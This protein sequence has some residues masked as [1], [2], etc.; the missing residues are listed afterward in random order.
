MKRYMILAAIAAALLF[1]TVLWPRHGSETVAP[2]TS[3]ATPQRLSP[4][5]PSDR[6][7][8]TRSPGPERSTDPESAARIE[9]EREYL[10][11]RAEEVRL[12]NEAGNPSVSFYGLVVD[13]DTNPLPNVSV[14]LG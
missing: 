7:E 2:E 1:L 12:S 8:A 3:P 5:K 11:R 13:Q 10:A 4:E 6:A 9:A 14:D